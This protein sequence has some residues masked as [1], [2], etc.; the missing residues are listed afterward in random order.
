MR[1]RREADAN[2]CETDAS[3]CELLRH[4]AA[5]V[6]DRRLDA[7]S[8]R[9]RGEGSKNKI[10]DKD[11]FSWI[12]D[13]KVNKRQ[14]WPQMRKSIFKAALDLGPPGTE[15]PIGSLRP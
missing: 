12:S 5:W 2:P 9:H 4:R 11:N 1:N 15:R 8:G 3:R 10:K 6:R 14:L 7:V 13:E